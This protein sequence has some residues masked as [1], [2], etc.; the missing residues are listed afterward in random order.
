MNKV[1]EYNV[2]GQNI[3]LASAAMLVAGTVNEYTARFSFDADWDGYQRVAV[4]N[5]DG[6]EREQLLTDDA[7]EVPWEVLRPGA[8]LK[9]GVYGT[10]DSSRLPTI[11]TT[12]RQYIHDGAG[13]T[14]EAADPSPVLAEQI[15]QRMGD[16]DALKTEDKSSLVAAINE[17]WS[18]GGSGGSSVTDAAIDES[19]HLIITLSTGKTID[20]GYAVGPAGP[21]GPSGQNG[22]NGQDGAPGKD[23]ADGL[24]GKDGKDGDPGADGKDGVGIQSVTQTTT[25]TE[26]GGANIVTVTKT[27][28]TT[29][30]FEVRNGS[31]GSTGPAGADGKDGKDGSQG[32]AGADGKTAYQYAQEGGYA[33]TEQ[34]FAEKM[35]AEIPAPYTLPIASSTVLGGVQPVAKTDAMT[36]S[37]GV[38]ANGAL[39]T[40]PG[41]GGGGD[42]AFELIDTIDWSTE[43][44]AAAGAGR[45]YTLSGATEV[46]ILWSGMVNSTS[47]NSSMVIDFNDMLPSGMFTGAL[48]TGKSGTPLSGYTIFKLLPRLGYT[49]IGSGGAISSTTYSKSNPSFPYNLFPDTSEKITKIKIA[50][51]PTQYY[52]VGGITK[53]YVR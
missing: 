9:V 4:F 18:S 24:P 14:D 47:T 36:Q 16:L 39:F 41:S 31:R 50:N 27:D 26:D 20:A 10:R 53:I 15:L 49:Y 1:L 28:G 32:P 37:V 46:L 34:E 7:C 33:G 6:T 35:A 25:S 51:P 2:T 40:E 30:T 12:H 45:T 5:A 21:I 23:G 48:P 17:V 22:K 8:Y 3:E 44:M 13:P 19:G 38:D 43:E 11:W 52:A 29:S 42:G